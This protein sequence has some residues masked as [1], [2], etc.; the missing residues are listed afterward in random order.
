MSRDE[1]LADLEAFL[2]KSN[3]NLALEGPSRKRFVNNVM[4]RVR[5]IVPAEAPPVEK[6]DI[7]TFEV[8]A[9]FAKGPA[10]MMTPGMS[11]IVDDQIK[12]VKQ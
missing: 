8:T 5:A 12:G 6:K 2:N 1:Q 3:V 9:P 11:S 7:E 10:V 4:K